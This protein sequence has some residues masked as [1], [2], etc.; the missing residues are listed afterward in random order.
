MSNPEVGEA[1]VKIRPVVG[2]DFP[3]QISRQVDQGIKQAQASADR[4]IDE[5]SKRIESLSLRAQA[6]ALRGD[7]LGSSR[8]NAQA[9]LEQVIFAAQQARVQAQSLVSADQSAMRELLLASAD[10][11]DKAALKL[12]EMIAKS[13]R[14]GRPVGTPGLLQQ[15]EDFA[16]GSG[17]SGGIGGLLGGAGRAGAIGF[18]AVAGFQALNE[19]SQSLRRTGDEAFTTEGRLSNLGAELLSGNIIGGL[20]AL[21]A[22]QPAKIVGDLAAKIAELQQKN[23][24]L[25]VSEQK[26]LDVRTQGETQLKQ[27]VLTLALQGHIS[28]S[29]AKALLEV[30]DNLYYQEKA[31]RAAE[32]A[33]AGVADQIARAGSEAAAFGERS[34]EFG[35][36][37]G[38]VAASNAA[39]AASGG[40][41]QAGTGGISV[42]DQIRAS[43]A[44]R[45]RDDSA[46]L[47]AELE[48]AKLEQAHARAVFENV[49]G[50]QAA[51]AA[52]K[53]LVEATTKVT[54]YQNQIKDNAESAA[55][56][57]KATAEAKAKEAAAAAQQRA[58]DA[59]TARELSLENQI[60]KAALTKRKSDDRAAFA[61]AIDYWRDLGKNAGTALEREQAEA[62]VVDLRKRLAAALK[63]DTPDDTATE[64]AELRIQ[65]RVSAA[66]LTAGLGDDRKAIKQLIAFYR[67]QFADAEGLEKEQAR[68]RL[69][70]A[71]LSLKNLSTQNGE[72]A[73][74]F[75]NRLFT[76]AADQFRRFG[77]N[78]ST[79]GGMLAPQDARGELG[80]ILLGGR[81]NAEA[82]AQGTRA[83][84]LTESRKQTAL[85]QIIAGGPTRRITGVPLPPEA[86]RIIAEIGG[87][88]LRGL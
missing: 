85:L 34:G 9:Q 78:F 35:R 81:A 21:T 24:P 43:I 33:M 61:A 26:L 29:T 32:A 44:S 6:A 15:A 87:N 30:G 84:Q 45:I 2:D 58:E 3:Q 4:M 62:K 77:S 37:V 16:R 70:A 60:A 66:Q 86:G 18:A 68:S 53:D 59:K 11:Y 19:F 82:V 31:A 64:L 71:R 8:L 36:G 73:D 25:V 20:K 38:A 52:Y 69:I 83:A 51:A 48:A 54:G 39:Q 12:Q 74:V 72:S 42:G 28:E 67:Q 50:T 47:A 75:V 49:K 13:Q 63:G 5:T 23:D 76:E 14:T 56:Q 10:A 7:Q 27:Y 22:T 55:A 79:T 80:S 88:V 40:T 57:A 1:Y 65:N 46:R 17:R 41:F